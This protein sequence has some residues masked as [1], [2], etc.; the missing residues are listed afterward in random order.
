MLTIIASFLFSTS[1]VNAETPSVGVLSDGIFAFICD[2][3]DNKNDVPLI[4]VN[5]GDNWSL[6]D[7]PQ[8]SVSKIENGFNSP[9]LQ[10][11][12]HNT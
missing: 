2:E 3:I 7:T 9:Y 8:L 4:F 1:G 6:S 5:E 10:F 12:W 11:F